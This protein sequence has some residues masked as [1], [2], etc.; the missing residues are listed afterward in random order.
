MF[1]RVA[2]Q[3][4]AAAAQSLPGKDIVSIHEDSQGNGVFDKPPFFR[5]L[6]IVTSVALGRGG[7][8]VLNPPYL[9]YS[10]PKTMPIGRRVICRPPQGFG[11]EDTHSCANSLRWGPRRLA[12]RAR[13]A[14]TV[15][16]HYP[17]RRQGSNRP[18]VGS[19]SGL[20]PEKKSFEIFAEG[21]A[22]PSLEIDSLA[23]SI[24]ATTAADTRGFHYV[25]GGA[26]RK[27]SRSTASWRIPTARFLR[28][29]EA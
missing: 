28:G 20:S 29:D 18:L 9:L 12:L 15:S 2:R 22:T 14:S 23:E 21:A 26:Y 6:N 27:G 10:R 5:G 17:P 7:V 13:T 25:Q 8:W 16:A 11:L 24:P 4:A 3:G 19:T 1:W